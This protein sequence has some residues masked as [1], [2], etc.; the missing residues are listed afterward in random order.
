MSDDIIDVSLVLCV[1][2]TYFWV[3]LLD[4]LLYHKIIVYGGNGYDLLTALTQHNEIQFNEILEG[5]EDPNS[6]IS[7]KKMLDWCVERHTLKTDKRKFIALLVK[8]GCACDLFNYLS[9]EHYPL[10]EMMVVSGCHVNIVKN[11]VTLFEE[12]WNKKLHRRIFLLM[13]YK[14]RIDFEK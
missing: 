13:K 1:I 2:A 12:C 9:Y 6:T 4:L 10:F 5:G 8:Y 11:N 3:L 7:G 14:V